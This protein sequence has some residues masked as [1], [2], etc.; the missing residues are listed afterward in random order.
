MNYKQEMVKRLKDDCEILIE[1][2]IPK[3]LENVNDEKGQG[4]N[5][6][7]N[8]TKAL[9]ENIKLIEEYENDYK[10]MWS[11]YKTGVNQDS[12]TPQVAVWMQNSNG[13]I[14]SHQVF[15]I[16]YNIKGDTANGKLNYN[17][18][19]DNNNNYYKVWK[20]NMELLIHADGNEKIT[21]PTSDA[22]RGI[23]KT[24]FLLEQ[25]I[26]ND[27]LYVSKN[28]SSHIY[29]M[30]K[31][32]K[33]FGEIPTSL[34]VTE[35]SVHCVSSVYALGKRLFIDEGVDLSIFD[36]ENV[37]HVAFKYVPTEIN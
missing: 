8:L 35:D 24:T 10:P 29:A 7:R 12:L 16:D 14:S 32:R 21:I 33:L 17:L 27:G 1:K 23:G 19:R 25:A 11:I 28:R 6:Y 3:A 31:S 9:A 13:D 37:N 5:T 22:I 20:R 18:E 34:C 26:K 4:I 30:E 15:D 36:L 2:K